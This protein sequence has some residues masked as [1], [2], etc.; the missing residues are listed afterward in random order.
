MAA[1]A[2]S[3]NSGCAGFIGLVLIIGLLGKACGSTDSPSGAS[4]APTQARFVHPV[5]IIGS[6]V[7]LRLSPTD[8][9][10]SLATLGA[11]DSIEYVG[12]ENGQW[13]RVELRDGTRGY[14]SNIF[15][16]GVTYV[17]P[18]APKTAHRPRAAR[19]HKRT[20]V[21]LAYYCASGNTVKYHSSP[22]CR[23]LSRC[24]ASIVSLPLHE[25]EGSM[26]PCKFCY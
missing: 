13:S 10:A 26:D 18:V 21:S 2:K 5:P 20:T 16:G 1:K 19:H 9:A 4:L 8:E 12:L 15:L 25:A 6:G 7:H 23:G 24:S 11:P 17:N 22:D 3:K 14:V